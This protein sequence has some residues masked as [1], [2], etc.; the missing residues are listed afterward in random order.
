MRTLLALA[1]LLALTGCASPAPAP[2]AETM[3]VQAS[4]LSKLAAA[5]ESAVRYRH[6]PED[7]ADRALLQ[8]ATAHDPALLAPFSRYTL[9]VLR[10]DRHAI[11]LM[12]SADG[13][14][15]LL[16]DAGCSARLDSQRWREA[17]GAPCAFTLAPATACA[18]P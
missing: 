8:W 2:E 17:P 10:R 4:A 11:V 14:I 5:A 9:K 6:A 3:L 7:L 18:G 1:A 12:C 15:A 13:S 16:E